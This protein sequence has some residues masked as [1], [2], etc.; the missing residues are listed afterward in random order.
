MSVTLSLISSFT[1]FSSLVLLLAAPSK[2]LKLSKI[3]STKH[4]KKVIKTADVV[5]DDTARHAE[6]KFEYIALCAF[7]G[8]IYLAMLAFWRD[9]IWSPHPDLSI[10]LSYALMDAGLMIMGTVL[11]RWFL[12]GKEERRAF[13]REHE[14][15][16]RS[17]AEAIRTGR[18]PLDQEIL[19]AGK[20]VKAV[21][22]LIKNVEIIQVDD[23]EPDDKTCKV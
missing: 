9:L 18:K 20:I 11:S 10:R 6:T 14:L 2:K 4:V 15:H 1:V 3:P 23:D 19:E 5:L 8:T 13:K 7:Q 17:L 21:Q 16:I 12:K 22:T